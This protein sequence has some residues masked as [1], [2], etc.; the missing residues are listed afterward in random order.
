MPRAVL[1]LLVTLTVPMAALWGCAGTQEPP[2]DL[3]TNPPPDDSSMAEPALPPLPAGHVWRVEVMRV[4]SPGMGAFLQRLD[5][6]EKL[7]DNGSFIGFEILRLKGDPALWKGADLKT[8][9][10]ITRVNGVSVE[11]YKDVFKVWQSMATAP[12]LEVSYRRNGVARLLRLDIHDEGQDAG[13]PPAA[14]TPARA[15]PA[16]SA[17]ASA[18]PPAAA[19]APAGSASKP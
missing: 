11:H 14:T 6:R 1:V 8:G 10:V 19:A 9:D 3:P 12:S 7:D 4:M 16:S 2:P 17:P 5:V 13:V 18:A 15:W